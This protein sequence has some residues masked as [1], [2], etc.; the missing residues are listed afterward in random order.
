MK[1]NKRDPKFKAKIVLEG[2]EGRIPLAELCNKYQ[3]KQSQYYYWLAEFQKNGYRLFEKTKSSKKEE[4]LKNE[5][6]QLK[7]IV[8]EISIELKKSELELKELEEGGDL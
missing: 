8:A 3:I 4:M 6:K 7:R 5:I 1:Y 2:L